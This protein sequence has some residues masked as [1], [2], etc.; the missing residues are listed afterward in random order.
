V[1]DN[2]FPAWNRDRSILL[3]DCDTFD[4]MLFQSPWPPIGLPPCSICD[5]V[6]G[7]ASHLGVK[8]AVIEGETG[9]TITYQQLVDGADRVAA[10]LSRAGLRPREPLAIALPNSIDFVFAWYGALRAG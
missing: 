7:A 10:S 6:L 8:P 2:P 3:L 5:A 1:A 4:P 9:R